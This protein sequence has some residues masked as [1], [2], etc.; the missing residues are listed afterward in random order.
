MCAHAIALRFTFPFQTCGENRLLRLAAY[1]GVNSFHGFG[2]FVPGEDG[3]GSMDG[4]VGMV[5]MKWMDGMGWCR[6]KC[7]ALVLASGLAALL[8]CVSTSKNTRS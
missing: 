4:V 6:L 3:D 1:T 7:D 8:L 5:L 2:C